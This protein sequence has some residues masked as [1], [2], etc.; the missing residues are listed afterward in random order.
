[1]GHGISTTA[2]ASIDI[3]VAIVIVTTYH[4]N[5]VP[6]RPV[7]LGVKDFTIRA[8]RTIAIIIT[9]MTKKPMAAVA[10]STFKKMTIGMTAITP[11]TARAYFISGTA[12]IDSRRIFNGPKS[13]PCALD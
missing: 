2:D 9:S 1:M 4:I 6:I 5:R 11:V 10:R 7:I 8:N 13:S 3:L 12:A